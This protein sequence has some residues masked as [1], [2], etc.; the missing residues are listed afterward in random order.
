MSPTKVTLPIQ[1]INHLRVRTKWFL[2]KLTTSSIISS[3]VFRRAHLTL[4]QVSLG[5]GQPGKA[6]NEKICL[7]LPTEVIWHISFSS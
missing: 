3:K 5:R 1:R 4:G 7:S 2:L 6:D